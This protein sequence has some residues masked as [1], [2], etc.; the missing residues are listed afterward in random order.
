MLVQSRRLPLGSRLQPCKVNGKSQWGFACWGL[1]EFRAEGQKWGW[2][3]FPVGGAGGAGGLPGHSRACDDAAELE[4]F[5]GGALGTPGGCAQNGK[6]LW[7]ILWCF[8]VGDYQAFYCQLLNGS[9][10]QG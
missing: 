10:L 6:S 8:S 1:G 7:K 2:A 5:S 3:P 4:I 9:R